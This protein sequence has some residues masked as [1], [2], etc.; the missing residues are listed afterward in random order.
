[1]PYLLLW[2]LR[3]SEGIISNP[4]KIRYSPFTISGLDGIIPGHPHKFPPIL[5]YFLSK[6]KI[7]H[8]TKVFLGKITWKD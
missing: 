2:Y 4:E 5:V 8:H 3:E 6:T 1:M 7:L